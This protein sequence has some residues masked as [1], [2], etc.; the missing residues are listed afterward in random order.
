MRFAEEASYEM[1]A[2][3][4]NKDDK[5]D[6]RLLVKFTLHPYLNKMESAKQGRPI[7]DER[8]FV[9]IMVPG[10]KES[11]VHRP[12]WEKD[13]QRFPK[14]YQAFR[15]KLTQ[16]TASG[17][18]LRMATFLNA[19]QLKELEYFNCY[20]VEQLANLPDAHSSKFM[21]LQKMKQLAIDYL[22]AAKETAPMTTLR[23]EIDKKDRELAAANLAIE[24]QAKRLKALEDLVTRTAMKAV[25]STSKK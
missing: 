1:T 22:T 6:E 21:G 12:V 5:S 25:E 20:T 14:Q 8:E 19:C 17:T 11:I 3:A 2:A 10:D 23:A 7:Y 16:E 13:R 24:E 18:P 4:F 9:M 15:N